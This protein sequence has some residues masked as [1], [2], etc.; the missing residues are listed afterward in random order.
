[1][2]K[3][4][5]LKPLE[6]QSVF[7]SDAVSLMHARLSAKAIHRTADI[8]AAG[9]EVETR[10]RTWLADKLGLSYHIGH[11]HI[12]D[13][14]LTVSPQ[15]DVIIA[16]NERT[17]VLLRAENGTEYVPYETVFAFGEIKSTYDD[18][19]RPIQEFTETI[20]A[21]R[22]QLVRSKTEKEYIGNNVRLNAP[23]TIN[24]IKNPYKNPLFTF[25]IFVDMGD[26]SWEKLTSHYLSNSSVNLPNIVCMLNA[27]AIASTRIRR[28]DKKAVSINC[29]AEFNPDDN[30]SECNRWSLI[31]A[32]EG[33]TIPGYSLATLFLLLA[34]HLNTC[35][36]K[37]PVVTE[38]IDQFFSDIKM[39]GGA[40]G[41]I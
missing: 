34:A 36:L 21:I 15:L 18:S 3:A 38:Y 19:K 29:T 11:G 16:S 9:D 10:V 14:K 26:F 1:M 31:Q 8:R 12:L 35:V 30:D 20:K 24:G 27:G 7:A 23:L 22:S 33:D 2:K 37:Y 17:P 32:G 39:T 41:Q 25:M 40:A 4:R 28:S 13:S 6:L 5:I